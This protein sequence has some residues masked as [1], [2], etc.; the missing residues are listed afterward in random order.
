M[1]LHITTTNLRKLVE[2]EMEKCQREGTIT[3]SERIAV[4][5][6]NGHS[7]PIVDDYYLK[8]DRNEDA[9]NG[10]AAFEKYLEKEG[11]PFDSGLPPVDSSDWNPKETLTHAP[12]GTE[13]PG[14]GKTTARNM[15]VKWSALEI[16]Y[17]R[18]WIK[19]NNDCVA[20]NRIA[21]CLI[22]IKSDENA[23]PIFH[24]NH[25]LNSGRLRTGYDKALQEL[26][27]VDN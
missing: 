14:Y 2:T 26:G 7:G 10:R 19:H 17:I 20:I 27:L 25:I 21:K 18:E 4:Q 24:V 6:I 22:H 13:H 15:R 5:N 1:Q 16:N 11:I 8:M 3:Q 12:W 9:F 23:F